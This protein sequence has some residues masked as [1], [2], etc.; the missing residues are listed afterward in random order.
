ME[1]FVVPHTHADTGW[2][3]TVEQYYEQ[4][5]RP[6]LTSTLAALVRDAR[7]RYCWAEVAYLARWWEEQ[8]EGV[9]ESVR[10]LVKSGQLEL[11]EGEPR[12]GVRQGAPGVEVRDFHCDRFKGCRGPDFGQRLTAGTSDSLFYI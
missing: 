9:R 7:A 2:M 3:L 4:L 10:T 6:I 12:R 11:V 5:V 8:P 1:V